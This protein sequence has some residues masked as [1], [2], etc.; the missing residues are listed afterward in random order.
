MVR[1]PSVRL[2]PTNSRWHEE[3]GAGRELRTGSSRHNRSGDAGDEAQRTPGLPQIDSA[4]T[5][6]RS[7]IASTVQQPG[8]CAEVAGYRMGRGWPTQVQNGR[9]DSLMAGVACR[10]GTRTFPNI[11][12][13]S[14]PFG[15]KVVENIVAL[16]CPNS[17]D[18]QRDGATVDCQRPASGNVMAYN[19]KQGGRPVI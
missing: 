15:R 18:R 19:A 2:P 17:P 8:G 5:H 9:R 13:L 10:P 3:P 14:I 16:N 11:N 6:L 1:S 12:L 4:K 7:R